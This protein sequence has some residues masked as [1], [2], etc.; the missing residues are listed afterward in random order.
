[1]KKI[2]ILFFLA[3]MVIVGLF[4]F[5]SLTDEEERINGLNTGVG[6]AEKNYSRES[7]KVYL[8]IDSGQE[9]LKENLKV[10]FKEGLTVF[11]FLKQELE[12][13]NLSLKTKSYD[14]G[15]FIE[16]IGGVENGKDG[17]YWMYYVNDEMPMVSADKYQ[18]KPE[19]KVEFIFEK[20]PF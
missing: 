15:V 11:D 19:D 20:S 9:Q 10:D 18:L 3:S 1:M 14:S 4:A 8:L 5:F 13:L 2:I 7:R 6:E 12:K 16:S 17:K